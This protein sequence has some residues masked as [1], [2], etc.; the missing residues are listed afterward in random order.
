MF[1]RRRAHED[2]NLKNESAPNSFRVMG[3]SGKQ[4]ASEPLTTSLRSDMC[5]GNGSNELL[6]K[7]ESDL[8]VRLRVTVSL[9]QNGTGQIEMGCR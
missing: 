1:H 2:N 7:M 9:F 4:P 6:W 5:W 3:R 8:E